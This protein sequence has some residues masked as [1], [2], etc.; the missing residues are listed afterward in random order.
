V[1][2]RVKPL[3]VD[4][5]RWTGDNLAEVQAFVGRMRNQ[6][7]DVDVPKFRIERVL[8]TPLGRALL[9]AEAR[10]MWVEVPVGW[11][12]VENTR[13]ALDRCSPEAF[14]RTFDVVEVVLS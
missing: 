5:I 10:N 3:E 8:H 14:D 4:A 6:D 9:W 7:G 11:W 2:Y 1:K 12:V 13:G